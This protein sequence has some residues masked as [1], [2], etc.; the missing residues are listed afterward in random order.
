M[1]PA[2]EEEAWGLPSRNQTQATV[3]RVRETQRVR[4]LVLHTLVDSLTLGSCPVEQSQNPSK[5]V[6]VA[7]PG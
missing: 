7:T 1:V 5:Q 4:G 6:G 2:K 3:V